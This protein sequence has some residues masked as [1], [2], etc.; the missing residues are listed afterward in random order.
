MQARK[1]YFYNTLE[2]GLDSLQGF[3]WKNDRASDK[4]RMISKILPQHT[5]EYFETT[6]NKIY[7]SQWSI[8]YSIVLVK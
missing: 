5:C 1:E 7:R 6:K 2:F 4:L 3:G 8:L